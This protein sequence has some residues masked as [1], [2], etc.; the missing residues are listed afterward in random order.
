MNN[1]P[2]VQVTQ[3]QDE[4]GEAHER[5][6]SEGCLQQQDPIYVRLYEK[7]HRYYPKVNSTVLLPL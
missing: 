6:S 7:T 3:S 1:P 4:N 2:Q 5:E